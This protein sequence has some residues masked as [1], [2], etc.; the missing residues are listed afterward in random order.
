MG[1]EYRRPPASWC[2]GP[3]RVPLLYRNGSLPLGVPH[4]VGYPIKLLARHRGFL[5][6][7]LGQIAYCPPR[8]APPIHQV[9]QRVPSHHLLPSSYPTHMVHITSLESVDALLQPDDG[10]SLSSGSGVEFG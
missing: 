5:L 6:V 7:G 2:V 1:G 4:W 3:S 9:A 10:P 8:H